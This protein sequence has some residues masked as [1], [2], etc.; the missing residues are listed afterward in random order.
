MAPYVLLAPSVAYLV[1]FF[2]V[3]LLQG[4]RLA[5]T[6][7]DGQW[8]LSTVHG[9]LNDPGFWSSVWNTLLSIAARRNAP[10]A[11]VTP[12]SCRLAG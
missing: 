1:V 7:Q 6:G 4:L 10:C 11:S 9:L 2:I 12:A 3:P 5:F 8:G